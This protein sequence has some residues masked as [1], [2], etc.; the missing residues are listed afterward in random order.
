MPSIR[1][2]YDKLAF[3]DGK[4]H[5]LASSLMDRGAAESDLDRLKRIEA[6]GKGFRE[7]NDAALREACEELRRK[8]SG[9]ASSAAR[10]HLT[11]VAFALLRE[12]SRRTIGLYHYPEQLLA[13]LALVRGG[14]AEMA[15]GEGKTLAISLPAFVFSLE[16]KGVH[17]VT[18]NSYL[19]KRDHEFIKPVFDLLGVS[20]GLLPEGQG[21]TPEKKRAAYGCDITYGVGYEFGF[22]YMRDQLAIMRHPHSEPGEELRQALLGRSPVKPATCQRTLSHAIIDEVDSVL[23]DEAG[24]PLLI[25]ESAAGAC[26]PL[27]YLS[28]VELSRNLSIG[29]HFHIDRHRGAV[30]LTAEGKSEIHLD[31]HRI[32]WEELKRP[33]ESYIRNAL[34]ADHLFRRDEQYVVMDGK[35]VIVDEFTGRRF[36]DR[37]WR[38]GLHQAVEAKEGV[39]IRAENLSAASIT[40]QRYFALYD[41]IC[42]LTGTASESAGEFWRFFRLPVNPIPLHLPSQRVVLPERVFNGHGT[43]D[44]A[45]VAD[46]RQRY[47]KGQPV[48]VGTRTIR[49]SERL[50]EKLKERG[51]PHRVLSAKQDAEEDAIV[52]T[53]GE[54]RSVL[55]ATNMAGRGTHISLSREAE[56]AGGLHVIAV[57]KNESARIDRQL[58]GRGARQGQP[59]S[60]QTYLSADD[61]LLGSYAPG[62]AAKLRSM[63]AD[64]QGELPGKLKSQF[65]GVQRKVERLRYEG[66]RR[67]AERDKWLEETRQ[68]IAQ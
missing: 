49:D 11:E 44:E 34:K 54:A 26:P 63:P 67:M 48:L 21:A 51:I 19:A 28:A 24:C 27:P 64:A 18:V 38:E 59:G 15:T 43:M 14:I 20:V 31:T 9:Q 1:G 53:A 3:L 7:Q 2:Q 65:D 58:I 10:R 36:A 4:V 62:L 40:R 35:I 45:I 66:R 41:K 39:E 23:I 32:P 52:A 61:S 30:E 50:S 68:A 46:I 8:N 5:V 25:S 47:E 57:E 55:I 42:G 60:A 17:V 33:W 56:L 13:G 16:G 12:A 29:I 6:L 22:D 37:T